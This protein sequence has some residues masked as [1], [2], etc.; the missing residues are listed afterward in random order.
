M[1]LIRG[2]M[3]ELAA[4]P[5]RRTTAVLGT[6][7]GMHLGHVALCERAAEVGGY[8]VLHTF[9]EHPRA[10][11]TGQ[12]TPMLTTADERAAL[13]ARMGVRE[14]RM[15]HFTK[16][17]AALSPR[18]YLQYVVDSLYPAHIVI[19]FNHTF[20]HRGEGDAAFLRAHAQRLGYR[21]HV[22]PP[23]RR[24]GDVIAST[25]IRE[26]VLAGE[27]QAAA[28]LL[29]RPYSLGG[30]IEHG[31]HFGQTIGFPTANI[32]PP[33]KIMPPY[34][35]YAACVEL[36]SGLYESVLNIG[37][38]PTVSGHHMTI[39]A[40][41]LD[42]KGDIYGKYAR[43]HLLDFLRPEKRFPDMDALRG[44][45]AEDVEAAKRFFSTFEGM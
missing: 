13:A 2:T 24:D 35:V 12:H 34:G 7:D 15:M 1:R 6:F 9:L 28:R 32:H 8:T 27:M 21:L 18:D 4:W 3:G 22:I 29:G 17:I 26:R 33:S 19:G 36:K 10:V 41:L 38:R 42:F 44:G 30:E 25:T 31:R 16:E 37:M 39:E 40:H 45:I 23:K 20:G 11:L 43:A 5:R 14:M